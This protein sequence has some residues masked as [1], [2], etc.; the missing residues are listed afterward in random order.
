MV[1]FLFGLSIFK[2]YIEREF[3]FCQ[4]RYLVLQESGKCEYIKGI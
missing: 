3:L 1:R 4:T 2:D